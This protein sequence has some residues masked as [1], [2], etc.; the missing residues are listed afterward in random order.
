MPQAL[1]QAE[2][3]ALEAVAAAVE[4]GAGIPELVRSAAKALDVSLILID[5]S[6]AILAVAAKSSAEE[7]ALIE[8]GPD[9]MTVDLVVA[10][11]DVGRLRVKPRVETPLL[12]LLT[13]LLASEVERVR[14]PERASDEA[15]ATF[16][17]ALLRREIT[18]PGDIVARGKELGV[19][20][21]AGGTVLVARAH[22][23]SP[24]DEDWR[25]RALDLAQ[26]G[27]KNTVSGTVAVMLE[28]PHGRGSEIMLLVPGAEESSGKRAAEAVL[29]ELEAHL[30]GFVFALGRSRIAKEPTEFARA[31]DEARLAANVAEA[32]GD[33]TMLEFDQTGAYRLLLST[34]SENPEELERFYAETLEPI[35]AYDE[36]YETDLLQTLETFL[37]SD[38]NVAGTAQ[39]LFTHRHTVRYRLERVRELTDL[40]VGS[41]DGREK[42]S[43]GLKSMRV[44]GIARARGP[45]T[46]HGTS[47]GRVPSE[48]QR[49][50]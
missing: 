46:E 36:Q 29:R 8:A 7:R 9:V 3:D 45:A 16:L 24:T 44:L 22:P 27:G 4:S 13:A 18:D 34:M 49:R 47:A 23:L 30:A 43:L 26:R 2:S 12:R 40:D 11:V 48:K 17:T 1:E 19:D 6:S 10:N 21:Q 41:S 28:R 35:V 5:R 31:G 50:K 39:K 20:L 37:E 38:G 32:E 33:L 42:L 14:A 15:V 25:S